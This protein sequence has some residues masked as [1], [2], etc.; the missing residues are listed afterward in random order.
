MNALGKLFLKGLAV[1]IP[2]VLTVA[3]TWWLA[4]GAERLLG[5]LLRSTLPDGWYIPGLGLALAVA[6]ILVIGL[7]SQV[8]VFQRLWEWGEKLLNRLPFVKTIYNATKDFFGYF[9]PDS[10]AMEKVVLVT[11]PGQDFELIG[12][13]TRE[14]FSSLPFEP[15]A[16]D[17]IAVYLPMS[18]QLGGYTLFLDRECLRPVDMS[19]EEGMRLVLTGAVTGR[20]RAPATGSPVAERDH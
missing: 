15:H 5:R 10:T 1:V 11:L 14:S 13:V 2:L 8:L 4:R 16:E 7:L 12:F 20:E 3:V 17:P 19:F 18:Y 6:L 9:S